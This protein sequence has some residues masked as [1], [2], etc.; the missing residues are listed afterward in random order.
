MRTGVTTS[1]QIAA[2][3]EVV[4]SDIVD[5][6]I[7]IGD[8]RLAIHRD[9]RVRLYGVERQKGEDVRNR[10]RW[11]LPEYRKVIANVDGVWENYHLEV[12]AEDDGH[13]RVL[14]T[15]WHNEKNINQQL[16]NEGET[17]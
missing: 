15:I 14:G 6:M 12:H 17:K 11:L 13:G 9:V 8:G 5:M 7:R 4:E 3:H 16:L 2:I 10:L 1:Y